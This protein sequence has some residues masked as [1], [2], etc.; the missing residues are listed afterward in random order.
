MGVGPRCAR[1]FF[2]QFIF[3][4]EKRISRNWLINKYS[5]RKSSQTVVS[6]SYTSTYTFC[7]LR[8]I[9]N[10]VQSAKI[11]TVINIVGAQY[12]W[13]VIYLSVEPI[14]TISVFLT[15][16]FVD[17]YDSGKGYY[18]VSAVI[19]NMF[20]CLCIILF[21]RNWMLYFREQ[22]IF[23]CKAHVFH[24]DP[25]TKKS[26]I[27]ASTV[28]VNVSFFFDSHR[29]LYRIISVEGSK[30]WIYVYKIKSQLILT[31][32]LMFTYFRLS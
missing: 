22:T 3:L 1:A 14:S 8:N 26:W 32:F 24:I 17:G 31:R 4:S 15:I 21:L 10:T 20:I 6:G 7:R 12:R 27:S 25:K 13:F 11:V 23:T 28:A 5:A 19:Y 29:A 16:L 18:G 9:R 2:D 30:V